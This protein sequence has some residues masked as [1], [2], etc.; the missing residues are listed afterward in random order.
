MLG[1]VVSGI[2]D[3]LA[4]ALVLVLSAGLIWVLGS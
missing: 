2:I 1:L 4:M 3:C